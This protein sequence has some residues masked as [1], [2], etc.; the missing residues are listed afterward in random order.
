MARPV[1]DATGS[2][3]APYSTLLLA[4]EGREAEATELIDA[5]SADATHRGQGLGLT[6]THW[7][8][9]VLHNGGG[10]YE[11]ALAA[12]A[13][14]ATE[15]PE[16]LRFSTWALAELVEALGCSSARAPSNTTCA[17]S[18]PSSASG[19]ATNCTPRSPLTRGPDRV[20]RQPHGRRD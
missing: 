5:A 13:L 1:T 11:D 19:H 3:L 8:S 14:Q 9:A 15:Y 4:W 16:E 2:H 7:A 10:R 20:V 17:R 6:F 18:S 12:A